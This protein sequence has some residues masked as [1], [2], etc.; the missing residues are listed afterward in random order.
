MRQSCIALGLAGLV[1]LLAGCGGQTGAQ[2][3][4]GGSSA[5]T[6]MGGV[7]VIDLDEIAKRLG[8]DAEMAGSIT[9]RESDLNEKLGVLQTSLRREYDDEERRLA[10][11]PID[12]QT[13]T[14]Q[15]LQT[16]HQTRLVQAQRQAQ[17]DFAVYKARVVNGF[18]D[19]MKPVARRIAAEK[20]LGVVVT[21]NETVLF[22][23]D[24]AVDITDEVAAELLSRRGSASSG[25]GNSQ[26]S[27]E[28]PPPP[29]RTAR[30]PN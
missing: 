11:A 30:K 2:S 16:D 17:Q 9:T 22:T 27:D 6:N 12:E 13:T 3:P 20:G 15:K 4:E 23:Y 25:D 21:K 24:D 7:A 14:L 1:G 10:G 19:E 29:S 5:K 8:R 26:P 18:R 28:T